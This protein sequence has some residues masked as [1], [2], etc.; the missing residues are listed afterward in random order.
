MHSASC[1]ASDFLSVSRAV[2]Q[3]ATD[4]NTADTRNQIIETAHEKL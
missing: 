4:G 3:G 2:L 1:Y